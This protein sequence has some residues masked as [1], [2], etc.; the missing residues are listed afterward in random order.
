MVPYATLQ[1]RHSLLFHSASMIMIRYLDMPCAN[2]WRR[3]SLAGDG[4]KP[5]ECYYK[6]IYVILDMLYVI[7]KVITRCSMILI[8]TLSPLSSTTYHQAI[9]NTTINIHQHHHIQH[10]YHQVA[11]GRG[12]RKALITTQATAHFAAK[13]SCA[14]LFTA[15]LAVFNIRPSL[16]NYTNLEV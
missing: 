11:R 16:Q 15:N 7:Y 6:V 1:S 14:I 2:K 9:I 13:H 3:R 5:G 12:N 10:H 8:T 4:G